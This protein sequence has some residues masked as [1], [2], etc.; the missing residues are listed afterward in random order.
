MGEKLACMPPDTTDSK[1]NS[2]LMYHGMAHQ[3][4]CVAMLH[5]ASGIQKW[6]LDLEEV[7][8]GDGKHQEF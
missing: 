6:R 1:T 8:Y 2:H 4:V 5:G 7:S 3:R